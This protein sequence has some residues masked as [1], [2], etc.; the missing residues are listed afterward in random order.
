MVI[1]QYLD[2]PAGLPAPSHTYWMPLPS[3]LAAL[4]YQL[5]GTFRA[6][7][8]PFVV[9]TGLLPLLA[10]VIAR[11]LEGQRWQAWAAASLTA[12]GGYYSLYWNQPE[13]F[14][15]FAW[16][17]GLCLLA[18]GRAG[19]GRPLWWLI[20]GLTAGLAH[21]S[22][23][24]GALLLGV[25]LAVWLAVGRRRPAAAAGLALLL[26]AY[27]AVMGGWFWRNWRVFGQPLPSAGAQ[28]LFL[29]TYDDLFAFGRRFDLAGYLAWGGANI[30]GSKLRAVWL[31]GQTFVAVNG[32]IFLVPFLVAAWIRLARSPE[33]WPRLRPVTWYSLALFATMTLLFTF[34]GERGGLF[35][36]TAA[37]WPWFMALAAIGIGLAVDWA[38]TRLRHWRP[39]RAKPIFATLFVAVAFLFSLALTASREGGEDEA[40][41]YR[42]IGRSL[43]PSAVV[44]VGNPPAFYYHTGRPALSIPNEPIPGLVAVARRYGATHLALS[45]DHPAPLADLYEGQLAVPEL[46]LVATLDSFRLYEVTP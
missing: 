15:P 32:L 4:G 36:S 12:A 28:T 18:L 25:A 21:L 13:T 39:E 45:R 31:A 23:A 34:P 43:P 42:H 24:D 2:D 6:A 38:A 35:H 26:G 8:L 11:T 27:L 19:N 3:L 30:I 22:R 17:G 33:M 5:G 40:A 14:A 9:L 10:F 1:W 41:I 16:T 46:R 29:T 44:L 37:L 7:Q 20:A